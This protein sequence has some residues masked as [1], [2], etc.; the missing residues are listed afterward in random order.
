[1]NHTSTDRVLIVD[2]GENMLGEL[3][4]LVLKHKNRANDI[5]VVV[6][7][8]QGVRECRDGAAGCHFYLS[9][10]TQS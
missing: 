5:R 6:G 10:G 3:M 4:S 7:G 9:L 8:Q 2:C 1:M